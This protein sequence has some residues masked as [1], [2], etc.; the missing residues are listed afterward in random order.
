MDV[1]VE[2]IV[3]LTL[4]HFICDY[5]FQGDSIATGK[6]K[7]IDPA[8]FGVNWQYWMTAHAAT[9]ALGVYF[10][11]GNIYLC[12]FELVGHWIIDYLKTSNLITLHQDQMLHI[13]QKVVILLCFMCLY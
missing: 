8:K 6:N 9:H 3:L 10:I 11:T 2:T 7:F 5:V 12:L 13:A 4:S 1:F